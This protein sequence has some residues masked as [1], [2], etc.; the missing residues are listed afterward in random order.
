M[1][2][3]FPCKKCGKTTEL[4][5]Q[6]CE[7]CHLKVKGILRTQYKERPKCREVVLNLLKDRPK[8]TLFKI[9]FWYEFDHPPIIASDGLRLQARK[10][11]Q[12]T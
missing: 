2:Y 7:E 8:L 1:P 9:A 4:L 3:H 6:Y 5:S 12:E 10:M 11:L